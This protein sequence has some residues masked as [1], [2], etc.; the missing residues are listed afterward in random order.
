MKTQD[1]SLLPHVVQTTISA[2]RTVKGPAPFQIFPQLLGKNSR[3]MKHVRLIEDVSRHQRCSSKTMR[4]DC[5]EW[6]N[7]IL[8]TPLKTEKP[9]IKGTIQRM[10]EMKITRDELVESVG[11]VLFTPVDLSTKTK[12]AF[13]REYNKILVADTKKRKRVATIDSDSDSESEEN[14]EIKELEEEIELLG[15]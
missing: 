14:D 2:A 1:W 12:T 6:M 3:K 11:D 13:T 8:L 15:L 4:L 9:D 7:T 10:L 5:A